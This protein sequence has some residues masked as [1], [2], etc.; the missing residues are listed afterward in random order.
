MSKLESSSIALQKDAPGLYGTHMI[1]AVP[2]SEYDFSYKFFFDYLAK[3]PKTLENPRYLDI[4]AGNQARTIAGWEK[5]V[6]KSPYW[7]SVYSRD[8]LEPEFKA[9]PP[10]HGFI[11][12]PFRVHDMRQSWRSA[13]LIDNCID[14]AVFSWALHW[15]GENGHR[16]ALDELARVLRPRAPILISTLSAYDV[17][18][19]N[20]TFFRS[21]IDKSELREAYPNLP[22]IRSHDQDN[23]PTWVVRLDDI[24]EDQ[25][26][27]KGYF[28]NS[29]HIKSKLGA[30]E[31]IG[32]TSTYLRNEFEKRGFEII[33]E[34]VKPN[35]DFSNEYP[36]TLLKGRTKLIYL[37]R[38]K[39]LK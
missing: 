22:I 26:R 18:I 16:V 13:G 19:K 25:I 3:P 38:N 27:Q 7:S 30:N 5:V 39:A 10:S 31:R 32:F 29:G 12:R 34:V 37:L 9:D 20:I 35:R 11:Y 2:Y 17:A 24:L 4:A 1:E 28:I 15:F 36:P 33:H 6:K 23:K 21:V 14:A 8:I